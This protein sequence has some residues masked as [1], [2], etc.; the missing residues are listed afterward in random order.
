MKTNQ[1]II[2][3]TKYAFFKYNVHVM[4]Q[5]GSNVINNILISSREA[6]WS[7]YILFAKE[8]VTETEWV[9]SNWHKKSCELHHVC[10]SLKAHVSSWVTY[11][12]SSIPWSD[13]SLRSCLIRV[14]FSLRSRK[15]VTPGY[16]ELK[17]LQMFIKMV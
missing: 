4:R 7:R 5:T 10:T 17:V 13:S 1:I 3:R 14:Y 6:V 16:N 2:G 15:T 11:S 8:V 12:Q 9:T